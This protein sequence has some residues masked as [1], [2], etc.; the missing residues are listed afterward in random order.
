VNPKPDPA[1]IEYMLQELLAIIH[2]DGGQHVE[3]N[4]LEK[5]W[6]DAID[7]LHKMH[8]TIHGNH[9]YRVFYDSMVNRI[10]GD[11]GTAIAAEGPVMAGELAVG[12]AQTAIHTLQELRAGLM[13]E[14]RQGYLDNNT[15]DVQ[16]TAQGIMDAVRA[17]RKES[18]E[19]A[20]LYERARVINWLTTGPSEPIL[21]LAH[22]SED[23]PYLWLCVAITEERHAKASDTV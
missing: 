10:L 2:R 3:A 16:P 1:R 21:E 5:S 4:G 7:V 6:S 14:Y 8:G 12:K 17:M 23:N 11:Y 18:A 13:M 19:A 9:N 15:P 22:A 20:V